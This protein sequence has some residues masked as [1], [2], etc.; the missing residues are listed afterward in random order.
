MPSAGHGISILLSIVLATR[1][2]SI[3]V[4]WG[5][6]PLANLTPTGLINK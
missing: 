3:L 1:N 5:H 6:T 2:P 4:V